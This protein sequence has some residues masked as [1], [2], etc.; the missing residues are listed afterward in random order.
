MKTSLF[1]KISFKLR[2]NVLKE[3]DSATENDHES[4]NE[5]KM[6]AIY[7]VLLPANYTSKIEDR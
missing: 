2:K 1:K 7:K 6:N 4:D 3:D 5:D